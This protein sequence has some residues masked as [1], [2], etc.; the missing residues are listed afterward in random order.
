MTPKACD[1]LSVGLFIRRGTEIAVI[2]RKNYPQAYA[3]PAGHLD[4]ESFYSAA[5]R[6]AKGKFGVVIQEQ[7]RIHEGDFQNPCRRIG[8]AFHLWRVYEPLAWEGTLCAG[9][10]AA[11]AV[12]MSISELREKAHMTRATAKQQHM[13]RSRGSYHFVLSYSSLHRRQC[14][15]WISNKKIALNK[16]LRSEGFV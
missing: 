12:W 1:Q 5:V 11:E 2:F 7:I 9:S 14:L 4:G 3:L 15:T 13:T 10:D 16:H 6:K 8:G